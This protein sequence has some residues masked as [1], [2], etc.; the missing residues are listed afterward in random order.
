M[1][2]ISGKTCNKNINECETLSPCMNNGTCMDLINDYRCSC[3]DKYI[4]SHCE[5]NNACDQEGR[6]STDSVQI[7]Q[8]PDLCSSMSCPVNMECEISKLQPFPFC[9]CRKGYH[10]QNCS[11]GKSKNFKFDYTIL[12]LSEIAN[13]FLSC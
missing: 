2:I 6:C 9:V 12:S 1:L 5:Q 4:G 11:E 7:S 13:K 8:A 3:G 10:G